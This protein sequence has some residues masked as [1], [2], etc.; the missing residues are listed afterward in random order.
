MLP[1]IVSVDYYEQQEACQVE[2]CPF[3]PTPSPPLRRP[4]NSL[5]P[6][7]TRRSIILSTNKKI[8]QADRRRH[9]YRP[10]LQLCFAV[11]LSWSTKCSRI[12]VNFCV[13]Q[14]SVFCG[15]SSFVFSCFSLSRFI[16]VSSRLPVFVVFVS[17]CFT[18]VIT[19]Y[20][21]V[22]AYTKVKTK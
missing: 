19:S 2:G 5:P 18:V 17:S 20:F 21:E 3:E 15:F 14:Y 1:I 7:P 10:H 13:I 6:R 11:V 22:K 8:K 12:F 16:I 9:Y 4:T